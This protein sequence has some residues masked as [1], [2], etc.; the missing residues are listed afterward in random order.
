MA[1]ISDLLLQQMSALSNQVAALSEQ[2]QDVLKSSATKSDLA[3]Q[4][5]EFEKDLTEL[6]SD[7]RETKTELLSQIKTLKDDKTQKELRD[8]AAEMDRERQRKT[9]QT[10]FALSAFGGVVSLVVAILGGLIL[11]NT[12]A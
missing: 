3:A 12:G 10:A 4:K 1:D 8:E 9:T 11:A 2:I 6:K 7:V 5:S